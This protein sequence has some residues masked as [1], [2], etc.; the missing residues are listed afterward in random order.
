L[1]NPLSRPR[2][3]ASVTQGPSLNCEEKTDP[4]EN[5]VMSN[6]RCPVRDAIELTLPN[7]DK[8]D[9]SEREILNRMLR[10]LTE[11]REGKGLVEHLEALNTLA[12]RLEGDARAS[13]GAPILSLMQERE[14]EFLTHIK[15][16]RC[17][18]GV[19]FTYQPAPCQRACPAHI[20][21]PTF[22]TLVGQ[23]RYDE[24]TRVIL[25][26][27]PFPWT[28]GLICPHPC[29]DA[30]LRGEMD[31]PINIQLMKA[32]TAKM[33]MGQ[34]GY[35]KPSVPYQR[36]EKVAIIGGGP[37]GLSAAY[38]LALKG[39]QVTLFEK[40][41]R[42][43]GML[44]YGIP[45]Y[46]LPREILDKE[47]EAIKELGIEIKTQVA[48]GKEINLDSL[49]ADGFSAFYMA[50][51]LQHSRQLG[52]EGE[53]LGGVHK[54]IEFLRACA[55]KTP[56]E[57]G[58]RVIVVGG[59]NAAVDV[60]RTARR[61]GSEQVQLVCLETRDEMPAWEAEIREAIDEGIILHNSWGPAR[62]IGKRG[63]FQAVQFKRCTC[64]FD[65]EGRFRPIY[66]EAVQTTFEADNVILAIGQEADLDFA[67]KEGIE[68]G[69]DGG[70][71]ANGV[72]GETHLHGVF[73]G[74]DVVHGPG[75]AID[76][77]AAGKRAAVS[78]D[79]YLR[80]EKIPDPP[81]AAQ[82]RGE[83]EFL[84]V[85][86]SE[87]IAL[88]RS[89]SQILSVQEREGNFKQVGLGLSDEMALNEAK[90]CLRCDRCHGDGLC[91]FVCT[92][93]GIN[94]IQ[95]SL[96]K[97]EKRLAYFDFANTHEKC[98]GCGACAVACPHGCIEVRDENAKRKLSFCGT[99]IGEHKLE[100]C[101]ACGSPFA[102]EKYLDLVKERSD[103]Y[104]GVDLDRNLCPACARR[105]RA[106]HIA[107]EIETL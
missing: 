47:I 78:I 23:G 32:Y 42:A 54:G 18:A 16:G 51:G 107:G 19:C 84:P 3:Y 96:M 61:L 105:I 21:I 46:R 41:P 94:A 29:E 56:P 86:F 69:R 62:F 70:I 27:I 63:R 11:I 7:L 53:T 80:G 71:R 93:L 8:C 34:H 45:A 50:V 28:C 37:S 48:F 68:I 31:E 35:G 100:R 52:I 90:R 38:F 77:I 85:P 15:E 6:E 64:V 97:E 36:R 75:M 43:G 59:G 74:G 81:F 17:P 76:A 58:R 92:E 20:D 83:M 39:Y 30:C 82:P 40:L 95:L 10:L 89:R 14:E 98:I 1:G 44:R 65:E 103:D 33:S 22:L 104:L 102:T 55:S 88:K 66:D 106:V 4:R 73:S 99:F 12:E 91:Q 49:K 60:A 5:V 2:K 13:V 24:A 26:D 25:K 67:R 72:T 79:C 87:K 57:L 9:G 101:E